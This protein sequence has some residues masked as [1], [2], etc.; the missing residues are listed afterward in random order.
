MLKEYA[1]YNLGQKIFV[2]NITVLSALSCILLLSSVQSI[3]IVNNAN[4]QISNDN[5]Y[6]NR[7][8]PNT[9]SSIVANAYFN[10]NDTITASGSGAIGDGQVVG[11]G[12]TTTLIISVY[13]SMQHSVVYVRPHLIN[14][15]ITGSLLQANTSAPS[16][17][18]EGSGWVYDKAGHIIT[19]AHVITALDSAYDISFPDGNTYTANVIG[20]DPFS[21][22]AVLN[23]TQDF[24]AEKIVPLPLANSSQLQ[25]GQPVMAIG[26]PFGLENTLTVGVISQTQRLGAISETGFP[27]LEI[28]TDAAINPGNS[29]GPLLNLKGQVVGV[30]HAFFIPSA[31][32]PSLTQESSRGGQG[33]NFAIPSNIVA[34]VVPWLITYGV[35]PHPF[36]GFIGGTLT[37]SIA[38][39]SGLPS[40]LKGVVVAFLVKDSPADRAG[41]TGVNID[42]YGNVHAGSVIM[43]VDGHPITKAANL[44]F[45]I[46]EHKL[47]YVPSLQGNVTSSK[48]IVTLEVYDKGN[49]RHIQVVLKPERRSDALYCP[50]CF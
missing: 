25:V 21:D 34:K 17:L 39:Q 4:A 49:T 36:M 43:A 46:Q 45:Y 20:L 15:G 6:N 29:G 23:M 28:Q 41:L 31:Q 26:N 40:N 42:Q 5:N 30:N 16:E 32:S 19:N 35:Y 27:T 12:N 10:N 44:E 14:A 8:I 22:L 38:D 24:S 2:D 11:D 3:I 47:A 18:V 13:K 50:A 33:L 48:N 9:A 1:S 7:N 37:S